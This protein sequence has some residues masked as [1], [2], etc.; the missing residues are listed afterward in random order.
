MFFPRRVDRSKLSEMFPSVKSIHEIFDTFGCM[1]LTHRSDDGFVIML[2]PIKLRMSADEDYGVLLSDLRDEGFE[3]TKWIGS[4][5]DNVKRLINH[6]HISSSSDRGALVNAST[7]L[8]EDDSNLA[9]AKAWCLRRLGDLVETQE[10][11]SD[12]RELF[13]YEETRSPAA[14]CLLQMTRIGRDFKEYAEAERQ[15][16]EASAIFSELRDKEAHC[17]HDLGQMLLKTGKGVEAA[18]FLEDAQE[19]F[20]SIE[21]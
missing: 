12:A 14:S 10:L 21:D 8:P 3:Q 17:S 20:E 5:D 6:F 7:R 9:T 19:Y 2:T 13:L 16:R 18:L 1:S 11:L 4:E 15:F